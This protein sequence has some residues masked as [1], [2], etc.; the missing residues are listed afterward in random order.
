[1]DISRIPV[2]LACGYLPQEYYYYFVPVLFIVAIASSFTGKRIVLRVP[3]EKFRK[4]VLICI[5]AVS[6]K[7]IYDGLGVVL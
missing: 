5:G 1:M 3:Q 4:F 7:F 6:L 2:Y